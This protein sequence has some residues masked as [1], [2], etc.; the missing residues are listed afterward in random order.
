MTSN[1]KWQSL[2]EFKRITYDLVTARDVVPCE[3]SLGNAEWLGV[4]RVTR[5]EAKQLGL[6]TQIT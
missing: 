1:P 2:S 3:L 5:L 6:P 4:G